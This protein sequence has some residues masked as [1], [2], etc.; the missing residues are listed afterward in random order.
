MAANGEVEGGDATADARHEAEHDDLLNS[1]ILNA[2]N[3]A[4]KANR[5]EGGNSQYVKS[6]FGKRAGFTMANSEVRDRRNSKQHERC[7]NEKNSL[8]YAR[9]L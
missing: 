6:D 8:R 9:F 5:S 2:S 3:F 1:G 4:Q 7:H